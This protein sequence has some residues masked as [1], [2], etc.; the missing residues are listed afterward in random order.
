MFKK[1]RV[2][3]VLKTKTTM[4]CPNPECQYY[5]K[6]DSSV[7]SG[8]YCSA[9]GSKLTK[10]TIPIEIRHSCG[11]SIFLHGQP[12][13]CRYCGQKINYDELK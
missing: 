5:Q 11:K 3:K 2:T 4:F 12:K 8:Q 10:K 6:E 13:Y 7:F 9:C 1:K